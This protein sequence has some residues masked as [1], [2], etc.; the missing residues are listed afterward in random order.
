MGLAVCMHSGP[1][2]KYTKCKL[3]LVV[4]IEKLTFYLSISWIK[5]ILRVC[6]LNIFLFLQKIYSEKKYVN[7][8][9]CILLSQYLPVCDGKL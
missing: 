6:V 7:W 8:E 4:R 2:L 5:P 3:E 1:F 9:L